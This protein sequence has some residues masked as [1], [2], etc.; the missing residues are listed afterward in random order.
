MS[1]LPILFILALLFFSCSKPTDQENLDQAKNLIKEKKIDEAVKTLEQII[2]EHPES[3]V[4]PKALVEL[5]TLYQGQL[6]PNVPRNESFNRAQKYF[7]EVYDKYPKSEEASNSLFMSG[8]ILA[9]DLHKYDEATK[10][11][12]LFIEKYPDNPLVQSAKDELDNMGLTPEE[13]LK[14]KAVAEK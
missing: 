9:N 7:R 13:I 6:D 8:F 3:N 12:K 11:Y 14:K 2:N 10:A 5:A 1:K 4:A